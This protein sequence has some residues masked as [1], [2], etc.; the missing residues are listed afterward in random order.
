MQPLRENHRGQGDSVTR[1]I[2]GAQSEEE[3]TRVSRVSM[4]TCIYSA[5]L[6]FLK[7][8][9]KSAINLKCQDM[10]SRYLLTFDAF[11]RTLSDF[12]PIFDRSLDI[13]QF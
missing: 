4:Y 9:K 2:L 1:T 3:K 13:G 6:V 12:G 11:D 5:R 7:H 8:R 10:M